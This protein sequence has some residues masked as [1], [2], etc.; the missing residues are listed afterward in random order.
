MSLQSNCSCVTFLVLL[1][2][3]MELD[4]MSGIT[5]LGLLLLDKK[6]WF[7][8]QI[9]VILLQRAI[10]ICSTPKGTLGRSIRVSKGKCVFT[11]ISGCE[12]SLILFT[13]II[14]FPGR[15]LEHHGST[16]LKWDCHVVE[17]LTHNLQIAGSTPILTVFIVNVSFMGYFIEV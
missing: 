1:D 16:K 14:Y 2:F 8:F 3:R 9:T 5:Q 11:I 7:S 4:L 15:Y 10:S 6:A 13:Q 17:C 12:L